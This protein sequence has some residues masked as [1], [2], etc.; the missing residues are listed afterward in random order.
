[1]P[2]TLTDLERGKNTLENPRSRH[3]LSVARKLHFPSLN[4]WRALT[5]HRLSVQGTSG[6]INLP[7]RTKLCRQGQLGNNRTWEG[8]TVEERNIP[9]FFLERWQQKGLKGEI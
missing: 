9:S 7:R 6:F 3:H 4:F 2:L 8:L 5:A 1:M